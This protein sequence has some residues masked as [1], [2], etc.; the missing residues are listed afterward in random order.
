M[1]HLRA[2]PQKSGK[3]WYYFDARATGKGEIPLGSDYTLAVRKWA[4]LTAQADAGT[5]ATGASNFEQLAR[6]YEAEH[7]PTLATSTQA[8]QRSDIKH[9]R[10]YFCPA[11]NGPAP[12]AQIRPTHIAGLL[13]RHKAQPTTANRL[14][15]LFATLF[16]MARAWGY[17]DAVNP[18]TGIKGLPTHRAARAYITHEVLQ[19]IWQAGTP[20]L[21]DALDLAYLTG[22][23]PADVL[24]M[25]ERDLHP[26]PHGAVLHVRQNK[27]AKPLRI[28]VTGKLA[29]LLERIKARKATHKVWCANLLV[30]EWG[31]AL[32]KQT[33]RTQFEQARA[34]AA[35]AAAQ[36][37]NPELA[38]Q[39]S[40][41]WLTK[42]RSKAADDVADQ[43]GE[44]AASALLGHDKVSTTQRHY[45]TRGRRVGPTE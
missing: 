7:I 45:L 11:A 12:L 38:G 22:Q 25:T 21:R 26:G 18:A 31:H 42:L 3:V 27:T 10:A 5:A 30:N 36:A 23:R 34:A 14:K 39:I 15:R 13:Q 1:K 19:A 29:E 2:R 28:D 35:L 4:E 43:R 20:P 33:R 40:A 24:K 41:A 32:T 44:A 6:K 37:G 9:L 8:T 17:T 16:N